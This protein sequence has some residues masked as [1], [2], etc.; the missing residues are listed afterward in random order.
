M[1]TMI[2]VKNRGAST[3]VYKIADKG[4]R[5]EFQPG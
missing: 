4:I 1:S 2:R 3:V 5:R